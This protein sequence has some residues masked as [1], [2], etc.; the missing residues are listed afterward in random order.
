[1][2]GGFKMDKEE[3]LDCQHEFSARLFAKAIGI[4]LEHKQRKGI[5]ID[6]PEG[7]FTICIDN[8]EIKVVNNNEKP[9]KCPDGSFV[10]LHDTIEDAVTNAAL[11]GGN[12]LYQ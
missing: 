9:H 8:D 6:M 10:T 2:G 4:F 12:V 11:E 5:I 1:M 3:C 7:Q